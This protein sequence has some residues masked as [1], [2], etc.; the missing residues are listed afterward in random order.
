MVEMIVSGFK[1]GDIVAA[2][3]NKRLRVGIDEINAAATLLGFAIPLCFYLAIDN[4]KDYLYLIFAAILFGFIIISCSRGA[5]LFSSV[6]SVVSLIYFF[7]KTKKKR[8]AA[9]TVSCFALISIAFCLVF[10]SEVTNVLSWYLE[11]GLDDS[12]RISIYLECIEYFRNN[13]IFGIG[14][15]TDHTIVFGTDL[16]I[17]HSTLI[18][19]LTSTGFVGLGASI[20]YYIQRYKLLFAGKSLYNTFVLFALLSVE[21]YGL[22]DTFSLNLFLITI[23]YYLSAECEKTLD[24][25]SNL[26]IERN[27]S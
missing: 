13:P 15:V 12:G 6:M 2:I 11:K 4:S 21:L 25:S 14:Y 27:G 9:I 18:Q 17:C 3:A 19:V 16:L 5:L 24:T 26:K 1:S 22:I 20:V 8:K 7:I 23:V 10:F